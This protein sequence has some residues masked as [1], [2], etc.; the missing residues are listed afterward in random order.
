MGF[1]MAIV[2]SPFRWATRWYANRGWILRAALGAIVALI[3]GLYGY[4]FWNT[5]SWLNFNPD[6]VSAYDLAAQQRSTTGP[7]PA[8]EKGIISTPQGTASEGPARTCR[9]SFVVE[10]TAD[11]IDFNVNQNEWISSMILYKLGLFGIDWDHT[12]FFDNKASF[13]RGVNQALRRTAIELV[14]SLGRV[15]GT[16]LVDSNLQDAR[17][18]LSFDE[19]TW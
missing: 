1:V 2:L 5:Q 19:F 6:Y 16:S 17:G 14:D 13:Q 11:L 4:F 18:N 9:R 15:R 7:Q 8:P 3:L 10:I 12:P